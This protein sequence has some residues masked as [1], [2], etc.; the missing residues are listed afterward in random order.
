MTDRV[1]AG[2]P[3]F[4]HLLVAREAAVILAV[5]IVLLGALPAFLSRM[6]PDTAWLLYAT[7]RMLDGARLYVDLIE[8]NPPLIIWL[9]T[10][11][12]ALARGLGTTSELMFT[13]L[14][15]A[16]VLMSAGWSR[17]LLARLF[18]GR[19]ILVRCLALLILFVLLPLTREDYGQR[20][21]LFLALALPYIWITALRTAGASVGRIE[22]WAAGLA[23]G[24]GIGLK[25]YFVLLWIALELFMIVCSSRK[26]PRL[27]PESLAVV[28]VGC[29]YLL[30]VALVTPAYFGVVRVMA[31]PYLAFLSNSIA[32][33]ALL[34]DGAQIPIVVVLAFLALRAQ[35]ERC[36]PVDVS[37]GDVRVVAR[38]CTSAE[39][40]ALPLLP[41]PEPECA[42]L[43]GHHRRLAACA[44]QLG[45]AYVRGRMC[46]CRVL[47]RGVGHRSLCASD[48]RS[49]RP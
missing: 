39:G 5:L 6:Q 41:S 44:A 9:D 31:G 14:V 13:A 11:P 45:Q 47:R 48:A 26:L 23:A 24:I 34:G 35:G 40:L 17:A 32:T 43:R 7:E 33:T 16:L 2:L 49:A 1:A 38:R 25:P 15:L 42:S 21:H 22:S 46:R 36:S 18:P 28:G 20:E 10:I 29:A 8:V 19:P 12:V 37:V 30:T 3:R 27:R 4:R